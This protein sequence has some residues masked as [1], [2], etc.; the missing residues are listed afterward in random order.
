MPGFFFPDKVKQKN[1]KT[2]R[3]RNAKNQNTERRKPKRI[4]KKY[5]TRTEQNNDHIRIMHKMEFCSLFKAFIKPFE[6]T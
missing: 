5:R 3:Y 4:D 1:T 2:Q 6:A